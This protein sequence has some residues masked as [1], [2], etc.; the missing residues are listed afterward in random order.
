MFDNIWRPSNI[1]S[2][3]QNISFVLVFDGRCFV[4]FDSRVS[5]MFGAG[6]RTTVAHQLVS[7]VSAVFDQTCFNR[8]ATHFNI[9]MPSHQAMFDGV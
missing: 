1:R 5:N 2:K 6:M 7:T 9:S 8:L 4:R 3:A